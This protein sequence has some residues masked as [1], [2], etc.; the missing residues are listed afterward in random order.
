MCLKCLKL[1]L[2][3]YVFYKVL[4]RCCLRLQSPWQVCQASM[5]LQP[6]NIC[7]GLGLGL[8]PGVQAQTDNNR[9]AGD[10]LPSPPT[11]FVEDVHFLRFKGQLGLNPH[12]A[13]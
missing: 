5:C 2:S 9:H 1:K 4:S 12:N 10:L 11:V 8:G 7:P 6:T 13:A 3:L